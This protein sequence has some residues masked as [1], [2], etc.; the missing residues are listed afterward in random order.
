M[1]RVRRRSSWASTIPGSDRTPSHSRR[2]IMSAWS[3]VAP[4]TSTPGSRSSGGRTVGVEPP[5]AGGVP[6]RW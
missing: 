2:S 1:D 5:E 3:T 6:D 4:S